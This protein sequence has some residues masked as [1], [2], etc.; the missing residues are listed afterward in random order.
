MGRVGEVG[1]TARAWSQSTPETA[2]GQNMTRL[3]P[4]MSPW[5]LKPL[6]MTN[7][8]VNVQVEF[9][10]IRVRKVTGYLFHFEEPR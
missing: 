4:T 5:Q 2:S 6:K 1:I 10:S 3:H 7:V 8:C 9:V